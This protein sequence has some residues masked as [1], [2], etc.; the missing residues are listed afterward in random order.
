MLITDLFSLDAFNKELESGYV[1]AN[2]VPDSPF[3]ITSY[4]DTAMYDKHWNAVTLHCRGLIFNKDTLEIVAR[5]YNKFFNYNEPSALLLGDVYKGPVDVTEKLDGV[6]GIVYQIPSGEWRVASRA[7]ATSKY[8]LAATEML[9]KQEPRFNPT[10]G[11]TPVVEI[12]DPKFR[13]IEDYGDFSGLVLHGVLNNNYDGELDTQDADWW[14][15]R[16]APHLPFKSVQEALT[17]DI[18]TGSEGLVLHFTDTDARLKLKSEEYLELN[19]RITGGTTKYWNLIGVQFDYKPEK[20]FNSIDDDPFVRDYVKEILQSRIDLQKKYI[21]EY[22]KK[23]ET[24][25]QGLSGFDLYK[26]CQ[27]TFGDQANNYT[28]LYKNPEIVWKIAHRDVGNEIKG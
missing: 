18:P 10:V 20:F 9:H 7:S 12:I 4:M 22:L 16:I 1:V 23:V 3:I 26:Y 15:G 13:I 5:G 25:P 24:I 28:S 17:Y 14:H 2:D 19:R 27:D 11:F 6:L 8:A 21:A